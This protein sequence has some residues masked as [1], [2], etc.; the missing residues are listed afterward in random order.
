[1]PLKVKS[2][3]ATMNVGVPLVE[4]HSAPEFETYTAKASARS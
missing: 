4:S 3:R 2:C 1:M